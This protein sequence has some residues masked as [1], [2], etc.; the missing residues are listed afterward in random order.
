MPDILPAYATVAEP[1]TVVT[2]A[3]FVVVSEWSDSRGKNPSTEY[4]R[5]PTLNEAL[6]IYR[7]YQD[8]EH[9]RARAI[10]VF[11]CDEAGLPLRRLNPAY[12]MQLMAETRGEA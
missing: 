7:E 11:G 3:G 10:G 2:A 8:G 12:L 6:E 1:V 9:E 4:E 5:L